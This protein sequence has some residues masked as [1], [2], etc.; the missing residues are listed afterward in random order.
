MQTKVV[1]MEFP[2]GVFGSVVIS[3]LEHLHEKCVIKM[4]KQGKCSA[5]ESQKCFS[6]FPLSLPPSDRTILQENKK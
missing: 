6:F 1:N 5:G 4:I 3:K 2:A